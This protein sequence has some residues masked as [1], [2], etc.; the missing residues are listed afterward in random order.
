MGIVDALKAEIDSL[1]AKAA[2][3]R[4][5]L[6]DVFSADGATKRNGRRRKKGKGKRRTM[7]AANRRKMSRLLKQRWASGKMGRKKKRSRKT[8]AVE[9]AASTGTA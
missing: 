7:S 4:E 5:V 8:K 3:L 9:K 1:E 2:K 6:A